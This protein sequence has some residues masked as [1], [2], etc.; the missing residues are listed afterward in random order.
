MIPAVRFVILLTPANASH[1]VQRRGA[2]LFASRRI[3][4]V[5]ANVV[6]GAASQAYHLLHW[7]TVNFLT[8]QRLF[9]MSSMKM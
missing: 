8:R 4:Q 7:S 6:T 9:S 5:C 3:A 1:C 2:S